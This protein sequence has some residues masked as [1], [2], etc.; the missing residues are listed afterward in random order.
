[1]Q[2]RPKFHVAQELWYDYTSFA[3]N[4]CKTC[5]SCVHIQSSTTSDKTQQS[6]ECNLSR[7]YMDYQ[8]TTEFGLN[9]ILIGS[10]LR[11]YYNNDSDEF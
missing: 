3:P 10:D 5:G 4:F 1:M 8:A 7:W 11:A 2:A 6:V 9:P